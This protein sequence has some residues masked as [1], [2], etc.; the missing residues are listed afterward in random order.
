MKISDKTYQILKWVAI[1]VMP[2]LAT[3]CV[4]MGE[5]WGIPYTT[6][7]ASTLTAL[8]TFLGALLGIASAQ[9]NADGSGDSDKSA[10]NGGYTIYTENYNSEDSDEEEE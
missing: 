1:I 9:Y 7:I 4:A 8:A 10:N 6:Q 5:I 2:A 3:F